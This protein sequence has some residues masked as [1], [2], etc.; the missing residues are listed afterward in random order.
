MSQN[1]DKENLRN[2][3]FRYL[4][5]T[6]PFPLSLE[7]QKA[8]GIYLYDAAGKKYM[9]LISGIAVSNIGHRHPKVIKAIKKQLDKYLHVMAYGEFIQEPQARLAEKLSMLLPYPLDNVYFVNSGTE[10]NEGAIKLARRVTGRREL[11][12]FQNSYH[13]STLGSLSIS[14]NETKKYRYRPLMPGV[15]FLQFNDPGD[16]DKITDEAAAVIIEP[17]Q[18]DA[19]V[20]IPSRNFMHQLRQKCDQTGTMLI[21][22]E[23]Q[24][25]FGRTGKLFAFE[26]FGVIPDILTMAKAMGGGMPIGAFVASRE[27]MLEFSHDPILGH[28]TTFGGHPVHCA[29]GLANLEVL[30]DDHIIDQV[31]E[32]GVLFENL[33]K[34]PAIRDFRRAGLMMAVEFESEEIVRKIVEKCL[35]YRVITFWFLS[36]VN[37]FRL[38]PPLTISRKEIKK[39][40][41]LIRKA[42]K[43]VCS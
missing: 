6:S 17:I 43:D 30:I 24:T 41:R 22:D 19:G 21:F 28:I 5:Q 16:L 8:R 18:G 34:H 7:I 36:S 15:T 23:V 27:K 1:P 11:I 39:A 37:S 31:E 25:G 10:A 26:H 12:S 13:G 32:K 3:F 14:G 2:S 33:L 40:C 35:E 29:A 20:R 9:D 38:A 4:A 42:I